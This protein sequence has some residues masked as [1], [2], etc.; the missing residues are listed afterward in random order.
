MRVTKGQ[1]WGCKEEWD[2]GR[3]AGCYGELTG[4]ARRGLG[5]HGAGLRVWVQG[6][7]C[8]ATREGT[9]TLSEVPRC[10][11]CWGVAEGPSLPWHLLDGAT[12]VLA[13]GSPPARWEEGSGLRRKRAV[14]A[15]LLHF[16]ETYKGLLQEEESAGK[17][18]KVGVP[19]PCPSPVPCSPGP[20]PSR[21]T[22]ALPAHH[23]GHVPLPRAGGRDHQAA[24]ARGDCGA[25]VRRGSGGPG[26]PGVTIGQGFPGRAGYGVR[27]PCGTKDPQGGQ[28][29]LRFSVVQDVP[30][31]GRGSWGCLWVRES[32]RR[33]RSCGPWGCPGLDVSVVA[34]PGALLVAPSRPPLCS[35]QALAVRSL[36]PLP[37]AP[38]CPPSCC[39]HPQCAP[40]PSPC[41]P[42]SCA[43]PQCAPAPSPCPPSC[44]ERGPGWGLP[45]HP[46][47]LGVQPRG[48]GARLSPVLCPVPPQGGRRDAPPEQAG[49]AAVP[50]F[51]TH[52]LLPADPGGISGF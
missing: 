27:G 21:P 50:A 16:L 3:A 6:G 43:H 33:T 12:F 25:Q 22:G 15:V 31:E 37:T 45:G 18:I 11:G 2:T 47:G 42:S 23:E 14:L 36:G 34:H 46:A 49:E 38:S 28:G 52:R 13:A 10:S 35:P 32:S 29:V 1:A 7:Q 17:V 41:L 26:G 40:V 30:G 9:R 39:A 44:H 5:C 4:A 19:F 51:P 8:G 20:D 48:S 24:P